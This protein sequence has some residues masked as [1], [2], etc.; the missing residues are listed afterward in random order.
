MKIKTPKQKE[1][2]KMYEDFLHKLNLFCLIP[3]P[4]GISELL[5]N[6]DNWSYAHRKGEGLSDKERN[7]LINTAFW[8]LCNTP[9]TDKKARRIYS[10]EKS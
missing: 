9:E 6:T 4:D 7:E 1:K 3:N 2:I 5:A 8:K 10:K